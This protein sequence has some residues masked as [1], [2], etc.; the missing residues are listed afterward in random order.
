MLTNLSIRFLE[1]SANLDFGIMN[2]GERI[3]HV[4]LPPWAKDDPMLFVTIN[5]LV[6]IN[7]E[8]MGLC[9][10]CLTKV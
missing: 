4:K 10:F 1:N 7:E 9:S 3:H 5:R 8:A 2:T 6:S